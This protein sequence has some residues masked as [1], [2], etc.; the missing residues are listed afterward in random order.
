[1]Y[2]RWS[3]PQKFCLVFIDELKKQLF[4]ALKTTINFE[5]K[6]K[7][8]LEISSFYTNLPKTTIAWGTVS[9]IWSDKIQN[10]KTWKKQQKVSSFYTSIPK[11]IIICY[12]VPDR[13]KCHFS[14]WAIFCPFT[15]LT[16]QKI[17]ILKKWKKNTHTHTPGGTIIFHICTQ[18]YE[19]IMYSSRDLVCN[20]QTDRWKKWH[21]GGCPT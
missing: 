13:C 1:M 8:L 10:C 7:I 19:H 12:A 4:I 3:T 11:I 2:R 16:V 14:F 6:W 15:L 9:V 17:K 20:R 5:K 18:N 21:R